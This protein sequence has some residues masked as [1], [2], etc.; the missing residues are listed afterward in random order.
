MQYT[1]FFSFFVFVFFTY[2]DTI[3]K[4]ILYNVSFLHRPIIRYIH[5][6]TPLK[7]K[8]RSQP[9]L[10]LSVS[11]SVK[12]ARLSVLVRSLRDRFTWCG[13]LLPAAVGTLW[14]PFVDDE[15]S[16]LDRRKQA[17]ASFQCWSDLMSSS[18]RSRSCNIFAYA[19]LSA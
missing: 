12:R 7:S 19:R 14:A 18:T 16:T 4:T 5:F 15:V 2:N 11:S 9:V 17:V 13:F 3:Y 10:Q 1:M 6:T 8:P